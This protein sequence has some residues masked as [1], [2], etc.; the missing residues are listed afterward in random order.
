MSTGLDNKVSNIIGTKIPLWVFNQF[1][2]RSKKSYLGSRN[3]DNVKFLANKT[4]WVRLVSSINLGQDDIDFFNTNLP[5][6]ITSPDSLAKNYIL[7]AGTSK[8]LDSNNYPSRGGI[9]KDGAYGMLGNSEVQ[10][11]GY[12]P[13][14]GIID[15]SIETQG[16]LGSVRAATI[17]FKCWDKDQLDIMDALYFKLG[18]SMFLEWG[19]TYF[20]PSEGNAFYKDKNKL[21]STDVLSIDPFSEG[22]TKEY[23]QEQIA[24][25]NRKSEG[26]YDAMLGM[27]TNFTFSSNPEGGFNCTL[28]LM[29]LGILGDRLKINNSGVLPGILAEEIKRYNKTV[30]ETTKAAEINEGRQGGTTT[31]TTTTTTT[32]QILSTKEMIDRFGKFNSTTQTYDGSFSQLY[33]SSKKELPQD[34]DLVLGIDAN[35]QTPSGKKAFII[36]RL[37]GFIPLESS[38]IDQTS[39]YLS[40]KDILDD[41]LNYFS[42]K[43]DSWNISN[44]KA[45]KIPSN[46]SRAFTFAENESENFTKIFTSGTNNKKYKI[47]ILKNS[48]GTA[49]DNKQINGYIGPAIDSL[50]KVEPDVFGKEFL[51][52]LTNEENAYKLTNVKMSMRP[53]EYSITGPNA[54]IAKYWPYE[55]TIEGN[56]RVTTQAD[57]YKIETDQFNNTTKTP[58]G[59]GPVQSSVKFQITFSDTD[60]I[61]YFKTPEGVK[62]GSGFLSKPDPNAPPPQQPPPPPPAEEQTTTPEQIQNSLASQSSLELM[63]RTIQMHALNRAITER[64]I[65]IQDKV[66]RLDMTDSSESNFLQSVF[67]NGI[68]SESILE[69]ASASFDIKKTKAYTRYISNEAPSTEDRLKVQSAYGFASAIMKNKVTEAEISLLEP[70]FFKDLLSAY[71]IPYE[72]SQELIRG[73]KTNH[74]VHIPLGLLLMILNHT[75]TIYDSKT[76]GSKTQTPLVYI[77]FNPNHNFCLSSKKQLSTNPFKVL[78]PVEATFE[79]YKEL[80]NEDVLTQNKTAILALAGENENPDPTPLFKSANTSDVADLISPQ[81][82]PYRYTISTKGSDSAAYRGQLMN[83]LVSV[84]YL[85]NLVKDF[86]TKDATNNVYLKPFLDQ[87][88]DDINKY[89]GNINIL[90]VGYIDTSN[91]FQIVDDQIVPPRENE[92][93]LSSKAPKN[94]TML[95]LY[96]IQSIA[97]SLEIKTDISSRLSNTLA[98]SANSTIGGKSTLSNSADS[99][100][101]INSHY[102]DRFIP[103]RLEPT[104]S[105][106]KKSD[107]SMISAASQFNSAIKD[108][109]GSATPNESNVGQATSYYIEKMQKLK[110]KDFATRASAM[111]P[112]SIEFSTDGI[113]GLSMG[114]AFT[115]PEELLPYTYDTRKINV[116]GLGVDVINK[117]GFVITGLSHNISQNSWNSSI[118]ANMVYL[119]DM[120]DFSSSVDQ[121]KDLGLNLRRSAGSG[122]GFDAGDGTIKT[123]YPELPLISPP[124][125]TTLAYSEAKKILKSITDEDTAKAVF[126]IIWAEASKTG[127]AFSSAGGYNYSGVQTDSGRWGVAGSSIIGRF[128]RKDQ[129]R[130]REFA[131]FADDKSFLTFMVD[132]VKAKGFTASGDS[133]TSTYINRWWSP[134]DKAL[135]TKGTQVFNQKLAIFNTA[136][137]RY[138][139]V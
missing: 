61:K 129:V 13:M 22:V 68:F 30:A 38:V 121:L 126:A 60:F 139:S 70:V 130:L 2:T 124:P 25:N 106:V 127:N 78:I 108:F 54:N 29:S 11:Y 59:L 79:D 48:Y 122:Y 114:Q 96:G 80:F 115:V 95:P 44:I 6:S 71:V 133:W 99:F 109:Y 86:S 62:Q 107:D 15:V 23:I 92:E 116:K 32:I 102:V 117:V 84:D 9:A 50:V 63:L 105:N 10:K 66:Y 5:V 35:N 131:Q 19:Q 111:I 37:N 77:D 46:L 39:I 82:P 113:G 41:V 97:K 42:K 134:A 100:G 20:Y 137:S 110:N 53:S 103:N 93:M 36:R 52:V 94:T 34:A 58:A 87:I 136:I 81:L 123:S 27:V 28:K 75:C 83:I 120:A 57:V 26:N 33:P 85:A 4:C 101:F 91:T 18:Y 40:K 7:F 49:I 24:I 55:F 138:N 74:P 12:R 31:G 8:F 14:P 56:L 88:I 89:L 21:E 104:G 65:N 1:E 98:I 64:G 118:K 125:A 76:V 45:W 90:R 16:R 47:Q 51:K 72:V 73:T 112:V 132:R 69:F 43:D 135:Y 17:N 67:S 3:N 128:V 119:K